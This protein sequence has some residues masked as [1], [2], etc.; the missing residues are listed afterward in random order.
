[1]DNQKL[2]QEVNEYLDGHCKQSRPTILGI[3]QNT[4]CTNQFKAVELY[5][6]WIIEKG[7]K[8]GSQSEDSEQESKT[9][10]QSENQKD[11]IE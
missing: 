3:L 7:I 6:E 1:M 9:E 5:R 2:K 8:Y 11:R 10:T 4:S